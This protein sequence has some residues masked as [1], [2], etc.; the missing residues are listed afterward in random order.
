MK[1]YRIL[2]AAISATLLAF[3]ACDDPLHPEEDFRMNK[4]H[5]I[6]SPDYSEGLLAYVYLQMPYRTLRFDEVATDDAV[7]NDPSNSFRKM[8]AGGWSAT[9]SAQNF[10]VSCNRSIMCV[11]N[12]FSVIDE[13][14]WKQ[15]EPALNEAF[16]QKFRGEAYALRGILKYYLIRN[17]GGKGTDGN[18][19]GIPIYNTFVTDVGEFSQP[20]KSF[21]ES[22]AS[23][24][25]DFDKAIAALTLD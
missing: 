18:L 20:R 21:E 3:T 5:V 12:F 7:S 6:A 16:K 15:S 24:N 9:A 23:A 25:E 4:E 19:W 17:H 2:L 11:N 8:A 1:Y 13:V 14:Q 22:V 10:W